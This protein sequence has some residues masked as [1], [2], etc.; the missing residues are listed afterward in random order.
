MAGTFPGVANTQQINADGQPLAGGNLTV[1][2][3][4]ASNLVIIYQDIGLT[5]PA[6]NPLPLDNTGRIPLFFVPDGT[7]RV[8]LTD[9]SGVTSNGGF[10]LPQVPSIG[11][12]SS[13]GG[14]TPV[15]PTTVLSTGDVK[16][17][18]IQGVLPGWVRINGR[19]IGGP[20]SGASERA[21]ND[22]QPLFAFMWSNFSDSVCPVVGGRGA[23][24]A[25]DFAASKQ[26]TLLDLRASTPF[27]L[28]DMGN[29][30]ANKLAGA[31]FAQGNPTTAA[32]K[33]GEAVHTLAKTE[34][35]V[36]GLVANV[37]DPG[38]TH[39][40]NNATTIYRGTAPNVT[41][42][43]G[44]GGHTDDITAQSAMTGI[45]AAIP[46]VGGGGAHN[47]MPGFLLGTWFWKL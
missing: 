38:H 10:D 30:A 32:S 29:A 28:D 8:R 33:G 40:L 14:G 20:T 17:Q 4:G 11:A 22:T 44:G 6:Q 41:V 23:S 5:I 21:N 7:Y 2:A 19:T 15:D 37:T 34:L 35:P 13:G 43:A 12:S 1:F 36:L 46:E 16:W 26:I 42:G 25:A 18:P 45:T 9:A 27:G 47:T 24:A 3:G 31:L 39:A